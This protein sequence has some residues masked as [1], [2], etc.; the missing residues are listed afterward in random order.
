MTRLAV[1]EKEKCNPNS[2]DW[3]C[4]KLCPINRTGEDCIVNKLKTIKKMLIDFEGTKDNCSYFEV[5]CPK[6]DKAGQRKIYWNS[7]SHKGRSKR[8]RINWKKE[9]KQNDTN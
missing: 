9:A 6:C 2:C 8:G 4:F 3:L 7:Y 5:Y 1:I